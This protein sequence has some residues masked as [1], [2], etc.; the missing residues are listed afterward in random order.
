MMVREY[1]VEVLGFEALRGGEVE[2]LAKGGLTAVVLRGLHLYTSV[3][4]LT[5]LQSDLLVVASTH[6]SE[7]GVKALTVHSTGNW[8]SEATHGG[9]P[10]RVSATHAGAM[11]V[12][13]DALLEEAQ[14]NRELHG[15]WVGLEVTHHGPYSPV[16][17]IYV[18]FG[19]PEDARRDP[20]AAEAVA[21]SCL[22][23]L[24]SCER[25]NKGSIGVGGGHYAPT[26]T[27]A[28]RGRLY[29]VTHVL[30]KYCMPEGL[31]LLKEAA[32]SVHDGCRYLIIDWKGTPSHHRS[33]VAR[34]AEELRVELVRL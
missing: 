22:R 25:S 17:L 33:V 24:K 19:G 5:S 18:E 1:L 30:P 11:R 14:S 9:I 27:R 28:M 32:A 16:P 4:E 34:I 26:F 21:E 13:F 2:V 3:D 8:T 15:W 12:A 20:A 10:R 6:R 7:H 31:E 23:V 29:D